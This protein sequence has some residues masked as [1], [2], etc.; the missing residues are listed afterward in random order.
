MNPFPKVL[1]R[2]DYIQEGANPALGVVLLGCTVGDD[3]DNPDNRVLVVRDA[4]VAAFSFG[5]DELVSIDAGAGGTGY[6]LGENGTL[7]S[8]DWLGGTT[9]AAL[10]QSLQRFSNPAVEDLGPLRRLRLL[11]ADVVCAGSVGQAYLFAGGR[12][13]ALPQLTVEGEDVTI[14]DLA[15]TSASDFMV[16]TSDGYGARFDGRAWHKLDLPGNS[17]LN[18]VCRLPDGRFAIGG[19]NDTLLIGAADQWQAVATDDMERDYWGIAAEG[20][21]I[22]LAHVDGIDTYDGASLQPL[23]IA[24]RQKNEFVVLR[25][26]PDGVW[27]LAGRSVGLIAAGRW[28]VMV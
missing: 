9:D 13:A 17:S 3:Y 28:Q 27:S 8:F 26:G 4:A 2:Q 12:F 25:S 16:V 22:Y 7:I 24:K 1:K 19:D 20:E 11:G 18:T 5:G 15:G 14:E 23:A 10:A 21:A 6:A